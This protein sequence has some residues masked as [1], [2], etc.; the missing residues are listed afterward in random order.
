MVPNTYGVLIF[1][2]LLTGLEFGCVYIA[3]SIYV[4]ERSPRT[5]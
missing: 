2:H 3:T 4:A 1:G 5:L